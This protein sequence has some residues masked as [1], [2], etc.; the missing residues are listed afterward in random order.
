M[1]KNNK[2]AAAALTAT[3]PLLLNALSVPA[4]AYIIQRLGD[5]G[6]GTWATAAAVVGTVSFF[7]SLGLRPHFVR[8]VAQQPERAPELLA[9]QIGLRSTLSLAALCIGCA[10]C[11][12]LRYEAAVFW[13]VLI[14]SLG[15]FLSAV[16]GTLTDLLHGLERFR[17]CAASDLVTGITVT[18]ATVWSA[19]QWGS[20]VALTTAYLCGSAVNAAALAVIAHRLGVPIR[21]RVELKHTRHL[22]LESRVWTAN[23][24]LASVCGRLEQL[25]LPIVAGAGAVGLFSAGSILPQ[26]LTVIPDALSAVFYPAIAREAGEAGD[27]KNLDK[28]VRQLLSV[29][30]GVCIITSALL[31]S[32]AG[33]LAAILFPPD[34]AASC[35]SV[36]QI[37]SLALAF[38]AFA[39]AGGTALMALGRQAE[40]TRIHVV[41]HIVGIPVSL[42]AVMWAGLAGS[43]WSYVFRHVLTVLLLLPLFSRTFPGLLSKTPLVRLA[44]S[45]VVTAAGLWIVVTDLTGV[46]HLARASR[47]VA[48][49]TYVLCGAAS[50]PLFLAMLVLLGVVKRSEVA[51][52]L[53][54]WSRTPDGLPR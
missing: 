22:L 51:G 28:Q 6:Y 31:F 2:I 32:F 46:F 8:A 54:S 33:P 18:A 1:A 52:L 24:F 11:A 37:T 41:G 15:L 7:I 21:F 35:Q 29:S 27:P 50:L 47:L 42:C 23:M 38:Q 14:G 45:G 34:R 30:T 49:G 40:L 3:Q 26:R 10:A 20:P 36:I 53:L 12:A 17:A 4:T 39:H 19:W 43:C 5:E 48:A 44:L 16:S 13:C 25:A 9:G